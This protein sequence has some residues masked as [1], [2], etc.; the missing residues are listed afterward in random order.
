MA[1]EQTQ[2]AHER[3]GIVLRLTQSSRKTRNDSAARRDRIAEMVTATVEAMGA[4]LSAPAL[5]LFVEDLAELPDDAVLC[6]LTRCRREIRGKNGFPPVLTI[7][8]VFDRAGVAS[9]GQVEDSECRAAWDVVQRYVTR[10]VVRNPEGVYEERDFVGNRG[11]VPR[12]ELVQRIRDT[13]RRVGGWQAVVNPSPDDYPHVQR[14]FYEEYR[15]WAATEYAATR[16]LRVP[17]LERLMAKAAM[18]GLR[19][20][21][22]AEPEE[23]KEYAADY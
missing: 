10:H 23:N 9:E 19:P 8:D 12:P 21:W 18:P 5:N 1:Q 11:R 3:S 7:A 2:Q 22:D 15:A 6:A 4:E 16:L 17:G 13:V 20:K 14:R